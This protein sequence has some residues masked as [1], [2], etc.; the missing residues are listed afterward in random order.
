MKLNKK[1]F[2]LVELLAVVVILVLI[3]S[4]AIPT[5][6]ST[7]ERQKEKKV[8]NEQELLAS[9]A[10]LYLTEN[11]ATLNYKSGSTCS[12]HINDLIAKDYISKN[13]ISNIENT[14]FIYEDGKYKKTGT[15]TKT[16]CTGGQESKNALLSNLIIEGATLSPKFSANTYEYKLTESLE[17][18]TTSVKVTATKSDSASKVTITGNQ[19]LKQGENTITIKVEAEASTEKN[20]ITKTYK[21]IVNVEGK[22]STDNSL[23]SIKVNNTEIIDTKNITYR[24]GTSSVNIVATTNDPKAT[25]SGDIGTQTVMSGTT[26]QFEII[27]TSEAGTEQ[28]YNITVKIRASEDWIDCF[29]FDA[30]NGTITDYSSSS[31]C[32]KSVEIKPTLDGYPVKN[33]KDSAFSNKQL[34]YVDI[35]LGVTTIG[36]NA[37]S[38]NS[39]KEISIPS[40]VTTIGESAFEAN[41]LETVEINGSI[42]SI[43]ENVF[44]NNNL[45]EVIIPSSVTTIN[46][47]AF[48]GNKLENVVLNGKITTIGESAFSVFG[49]SSNSELS[50]IYNYGETK[51]KFNPRIFG[52]IE[53]S[54]NIEEGIMNLES[55]EEKTLLIVTE[56]SFGYNMVDENDIDGVVDNEKRILKVKVSSLK[57]ENYKNYIKY[58]YLPSKM[59][60]VNSFIFNAKDEGV[61]LA[62]GG[63]DVVE[64]EDQVFKSHNLIKA[65][66]PD[67]IQIIGAEAFK[68]NKLETLDLP[69]SIIKIDNHA[70]ENNKLTTLEDLPVSVVNIGISAFANNDIKKIIIPKNVT[71]IGKQAFYNNE[72]LEEVHLGY[73]VD[74]NLTL[75][76]GSDIFGSSSS[77]P[78]CNFI[79]TYEAPDGTVTE[80]ARFEMTSDISE[81]NN[82]T[83]YKDQ[84]TIGSIND[85]LT[86][87]NLMA[88]NSTTAKTC[89]NTSGYKTTVHTVC[90]TNC[91]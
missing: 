70:F 23:K 55:S 75:T 66:F 57:T 85:P 65:V 83:Y 51:I 39:L 7:L 43:R 34:T 38:N 81:Y 47:F 61:E 90:F 11:A 16:E 10:E 32:S 89:V 4:I 86:L 46:M 68:N 5:I 6:T 87:I 17:E 18:G 30:I 20:P 1:G 80:K 72:E 77:S 78:V 26:Y 71:W 82:L 59:T 48:A 60:N 25:V 36:D 13:N 67:N 3:V 22:K 50:T 44:A 21:V 31:T 8:T 84:N 54:E 45:K 88:S 76:F 79:K 41:N 29:K 15:C 52:Y 33:I 19:N 37:F 64:I 40:S 53:G 14:C 28:K 74:T 69:K 42:T 35:P 24:Y 73:K 9:A 56:D 49:N 58:L 91:N 2:T 63:A 12:V 27:V 62:A